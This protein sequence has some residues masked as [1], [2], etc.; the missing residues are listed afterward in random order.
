MISVP[1]VHS[2]VHSQKRKLKKSHEDSKLK[3]KHSE[4]HS[5]KRKLQSSH[6]DPERKS[7][8]RKKSKHSKKSKGSSKENR[9]DT[10]VDSRSRKRKRS[11]SK[12]GPKNGSSS[13]NY[14]LSI[15]SKFVESPSMDGAD[16]EELDAIE[17]RLSQNPMFDLEKWLTLLDDL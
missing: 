6:E 16:F 4:A 5:E 13:N 14:S 9:S 17:N 12:N 1:A 2:P 7:K 8:H 10:A 11:D 15:N 3:S